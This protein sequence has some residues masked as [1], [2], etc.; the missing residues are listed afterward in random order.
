MRNLFRISLSLFGLA[1][2]AAQPP[3]PDF[4]SAG[5]HI[6]PFPESD[7]LAGRVR[8]IFRTL[9]GSDS[10][11]I[12]ARDMALSRVVLQGREVAYAYSGRVLRLSAPDAPG[13]Y[14]LEIE[15]GTRPSQ[16]VYFLGWKDSIPWNEQVWTQGQGK[17]TSHWVPSF[18]DMTEKLVFS[19]TID[20]PQEYQVIANGKLLGTRDKGGIRTWEY[21]MEK[22][23]SS[24]LLAFAA[25][26]FQ[27]F[28]G[29]SSSGVPLKLFFP[30]GRDLEAARAY[31]HTREV[32][33]F[34]EKEI[35]VPYP[36]QNYKQVPLHDFI[37]AGMENTGTTFFSDRFLTDS[38]GPASRD[39]LN[40]NA[41]ELAHQWF[42]NLVTETDGGQHW[43]HEGFATYYAHRATARIRGGEEFYWTLL[44]TAY[45]LRELDSS[46]DGKSLL[47]PGAGSL[48]FYE[49]GAWALFALQQAMGEEAF[50]A[51]MKLFL[52]KYAYGNATV[53][54]LLE[55]MASNTS[56]SL[57]AFRQTWLEAS[58]F[59]MAEAETL[60]EGSSPSVARFLEFRRRDSLERNDPGVLNA[61]WE[62]DTLEPY[63]AALLGAYSGRLEEALF[64]MASEDGRPRV[65][66]ALLDRIT[67]T[68]PWMQ[69]YLEAFLDAPDYNLRETA[70]FWAWQGYPESRHDLLRKAASN[71]TLGDLQVRQLWWL[72]ALYSEYDTEAARV[73]YLTA[74]RETTAPH[75][76]REIRENALRM[77]HRAGALNG[78]NLADLVVAT[79]HYAWQ[80]KLYARRLLDTLLED[81]EGRDFWLSLGNRF[82]AASFPYFHAKLR[83]L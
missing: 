29:T 11:R 40:V 4:L 72:L 21:R 10:L 12:D 19:L 28:E 59:P 67:G 15:Y 63:R 82:P 73:G 33:D 24:Y 13:E 68:E 38:L 76:N 61:Y 37:Y 66:R 55:A 26:H 46:G 30:P 52:Q 17:Y 69:P 16:A 54:Q 78:E 83:E 5:I 60:L 49:K 41:H 53:D 50:R 3:A 9:P 48:V 62:R 20:F 58:G 80:F 47:D 74:L 71:G 64:Q 8:F 1:L 51:G 77:L 79:E 42:G 65:A 14:E 32:F 81:P 18:D 7:S 56:K 75:H 36:W 23:M 57:D 35:G 2:A 6:R 34:L 44:G 22:P 43:L 25:G 39:Y 45:S 31:A 70:L 27:Y